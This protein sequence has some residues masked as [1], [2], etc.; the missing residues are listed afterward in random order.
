MCPKSSTLPSNEEAPAAPSQRP[1]PHQLQDPSLST[2]GLFRSHYHSVYDT[3]EAVD[4]TGD[5]AA[6]LRRLTQVTQVVASTLYALVAGKDSAA[7]QVPEV[8]VDQEWVSM[9]E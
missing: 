2:C 7:G 5:A 9:A 6:L 4:F 3:A 8:A 1:R